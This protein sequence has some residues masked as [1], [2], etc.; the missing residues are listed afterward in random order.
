MKGCVPPS[1]ATERFATTHWSVVLAAGG[2]DTPTARQ[3]WDQLTR[4]IWRPLYA[5]ARR[6]GQSHA[7]AQDVV[8]A[9]FAQM[10]QQPLLERAQRGRGRFRTFLLA[11]LDHF[12]ANDHDR[13]TALKRGGAFTFV[14]WPDDHGE[15]I[16]EPAQP[17]LPVERQFD[18]E[19]ARTTF[20]N[21][22]RRLEQE[23]VSEGKQTYFAALAPFLSQPPAAGEYERVAV[24]LGIRP[25]LMATVVSRLRRRFRDLVRAE[26]AATVATTTE[27]DAELTYLVELMTG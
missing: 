10:L 19:W 2:V 15:P 12:L 7:D 14:S 24:Q 22:L 1:P 3:A 20:A 4:A 9:F 17:G 21:A 13:A 25:G 5:H 6:R 11:T 23:F 27:I 8:Q 26:I 16:V 18:L